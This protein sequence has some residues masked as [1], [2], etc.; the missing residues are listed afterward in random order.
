MGVS[1]RNGGIVLTVIPFAAYS[2]A[3]ALVR[4]ITPPLDAE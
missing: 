2:R 4:A 1:T 3:R